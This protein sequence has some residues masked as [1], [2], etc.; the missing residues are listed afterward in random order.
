MPTI[1]EVVKEEKTVC[2]VVPWT[3]MHW[4]IGDQNGCRDRAGCFCVNQELKI[5]SP[6]LILPWVPGAQWN[7]HLVLTQMENRV[8]FLCLMMWIFIVLMSFVLILSTSVLFWPL[9]FTVSISSFS[10]TSLVD[11][12]E[13]CHDCSGQSFVLLFFYWV[14]ILVNFL[15]NL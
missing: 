2:P 7:G 6:T 5:F 12:P 14:I 9:P 13:C 11:L 3:T 10:G 15:S 1:W 8:S 4:D